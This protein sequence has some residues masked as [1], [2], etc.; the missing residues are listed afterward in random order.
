MVPRVA[1]MMVDVC[2]PLPGCVEAMAMWEDGDEERGYADSRDEVVAK[3]SQM[4]GYGSG[5]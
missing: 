3:S 5:K 4:G 2:T 1:R